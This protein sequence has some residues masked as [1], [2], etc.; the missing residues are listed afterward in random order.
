M[1]TK[2][3]RYPTAEPFL[4]VKLTL[5]A[6]REA[7]KG[8]EGCD[9]YQ[10]ATQTVFGEGPKAARVMFVGEQP[11]DYE[12]LEGKPVVGPGWKSFPLHASFTILSTA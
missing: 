2:T 4:P 7:S 11:G 9:L 6:L 12:D 10:S 1:A 8:C 3:A 5:P